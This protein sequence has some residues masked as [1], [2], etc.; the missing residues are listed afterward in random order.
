M[1]GNTIISGLNINLNTIHY[2]TSFEFASGGFGLVFAH[3]LNVGYYQAAYSHIHINLHRAN[4]HAQKKQTSKAKDLASISVLV[5]M[6]DEYEPDHNIQIDHI[7][8]FIDEIDVLLLRLTSMLRINLF[9]EN[10]QKKEGII[11]NVYYIMYLNPF[12]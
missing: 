3:A 11:T 1:V 12:L 5:L 4:T 2:V 10:R 9:L 7:S 8:R 6:K